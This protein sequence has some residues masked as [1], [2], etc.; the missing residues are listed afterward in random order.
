ML[1]LGV[2][3]SAQILWN[4]GD[5]SFKVRDHA[6]PDLRQIRFLKATI[7]IVVSRNKSSRKHPARPVPG[8]AQICPNIPTWI[9]SH[10]GKPSGQGPG[11]VPGGVP[12]WGIPRSEERRVG[13]E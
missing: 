10:W 13:K 2:E 5:A 11:G 8:Q 4:R 3:R 9:C 1:R 7:H 12:P 6:G